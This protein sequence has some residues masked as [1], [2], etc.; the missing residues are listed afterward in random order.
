MN[1]HEEAAKAI[2]SNVIYITL[3]S[4]GPDGVPWNSPVYAAFDEAY[5]FFWV[6]ASPG[7]PF[8]KHHS[9][10]SRCHRRL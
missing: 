1:A 5:H 3:A 8:P 7:A 9:H 2:L 10:P 6:S 4:V